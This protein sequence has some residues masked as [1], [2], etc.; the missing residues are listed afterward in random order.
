[1]KH[2]ER[3]IRTS[4]DLFADMM[5]L[6]PADDH[7]EELWAFSIIYTDPDHPT[8]EERIQIMGGYERCCQQCATMVMTPPFP[9]KD[10]RI[11]TRRG[12][13]AEELLA[14]GMRQEKKYQEE[15]NAQLL[16]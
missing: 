15:R 10:L 8:W 12:A 2:K 14:E 7:D 11:E 6:R 13:A 1:M 5:K 9:M 4:G 3:N 16:N